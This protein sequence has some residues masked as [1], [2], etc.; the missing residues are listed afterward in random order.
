MDVISGIKEHQDALRRATYH[1]LTKVAECI[2]VEGGMFENVL[3]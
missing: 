2:D 3:Y 1:V